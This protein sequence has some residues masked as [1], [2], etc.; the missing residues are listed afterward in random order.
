MKNQAILIV[1]FMVFITFIIA[2]MIIPN[3]SANL[4]ISGK[5]TD[6][7]TGNVAAIVVPTMM[8]LTP[9]MI[10]VTFIIFFSVR[11]IQDMHKENRG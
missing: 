3:I 7:P 9:L 4:S 10:I 5:V 1:L 8:W 11:S 6:S 2:T